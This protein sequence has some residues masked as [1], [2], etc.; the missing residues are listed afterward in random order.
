MP[1]PPR[2]YTI[3]CSCGFA[4]FI[5]N[6]TPCT[7]WAFDH[8]PLFGDERAYPTE[9]KYLKKIVYKKEKVHLG[10]NT[11]LRVIVDSYL[12]VVGGTSSYVAV[13]R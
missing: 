11:K 2:Y 5:V 1:K 6:R 13:L 3:C 4:G 9:K 7:I 10:R 12:Y 8:R